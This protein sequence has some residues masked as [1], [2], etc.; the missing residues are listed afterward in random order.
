MVLLRWQFHYFL[1]YSSELEVVL[2]LKIRS[3]CSLQPCWKWGCREMRVYTPTVGFYSHNCELTSTTKASYDCPLDLS[4]LKK[5]KKKKLVFTP[6]SEEFL[7]HRFHIFLS[8]H[9]W[10]PTLFLHQHQSP[11]LSQC[12]LMD[13]QHPMGW[14][15][16]EMWKSEE[17]RGCGEKGW[18]CFTEMSKICLYFLSSMKSRNKH[19]IVL[20]L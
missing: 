12:R 17:C 1:L 3:H 8:N 6:T 5:K 9:L 20:V 2:D 7:S 16:V 19:N 10:I 11:Q 18:V 4:G 13:P 15:F 14:C